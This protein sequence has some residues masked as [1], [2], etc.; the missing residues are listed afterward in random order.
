MKCLKEPHSSNVVMMVEITCFKKHIQKYG[1]FKGIDV[2][3]N[4][5]GWQN[6]TRILFQWLNRLSYWFV[7]FPLA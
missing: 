6:K 3:G 1:N 2:E 4:F 7:I 5:K